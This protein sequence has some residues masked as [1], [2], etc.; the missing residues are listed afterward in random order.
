[1]REILFVLVLVVAVVFLVM[2]P[3]L[4]QSVVDWFGSQVQAVLDTLRR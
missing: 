4:V 2:H 1:M 3:D